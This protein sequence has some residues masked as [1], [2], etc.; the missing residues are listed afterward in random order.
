MRFL[1]FF[2]VL[3]ISI[4]A[5]LSF[6]QTM[7]VDG[8]VFDTSGVAPLSNALIMATRIDDSVLLGFTRSDAQGNF[9]LTGFE[10]DTFMLTVDHPRYD[11]KI[12]FMFGSDKNY[13]ISIP[14][15]VMPSKA[16]ELGEIVIYA[17]KD[18]IYYRGDT[19]VFT[20][21]SFKVD[22]NAVVEDLLK[23]LPGIE[24]DDNG[25]IKSQ[26]QDISKVLVDGDEFFG[27]DPTIATK[28]LGAKAVESVE[29]YE[30]DNDNNAEGE[31]DKIQVLDL[32][33][34]DDYKAGYFGK[35]GGASDFALTPINGEIGTNPFYEGEL[36]FNKFNG[37]Q[38]LS[39]FA[40]TTNTP[41]SSF[42]WGDAMKFGLDNENTSGSRWSPNSSSN[43]SGIPRTFRTGVYFSDKIGKQKKAKL[44][45]NYSF[46]KTELNAITSSE[47]QFFLRDTTYFTEDKTSDNNSQ[48]SHR[49]NVSIELPI[50]SLTT[51]EVRTSGQFDKAVSST[52]DVTEFIDREG[53]N[54]LRTD[55]FNSNQSEGYELDNRVRLDKKF[56][57]KKRRLELEYNF[58]I[59]DAQTDGNLYSTNSFL[60]PL[61]GLS[62]TTD[63]EK[64]N[65]NGRQNH[66]ST[67]TYTE[68][69]GKRMKLELEY[70]LEYGLS[71]QDKSTFDF[72]GD[73]YSVFNDS[74]SNIFDNTRVQNRIGLR[75]IYESKKQYFHVGARV[76]K[77]EI[78]NF[79]KVTG[80]GINQDIIN[81][82]PRVMYRYKPSMSKRFV[83]KYET[84]SQQP[85]INNLMPVPDN[86]NPN[87]I[88]IGNPN[89]VPNY[90]HS[91]N[92]RMS[93]WQAMSGK[94]VWISSNLNWINNGFADSTSYDEIGRSYSKT[95]NV[96][97]NMYT[98]LNG[99]AGFPIYKRIIEIR[100][101]INA[102]YN[103]YY[104]YVNQAKNET[105]NL[106]AGGGL[107]LEF[108]WD[109]LEIQLG[110]NWSY[111]NPVSSVNIASNTPFTTQRYRAEFD[112]TL[113]HGFKIGTDITY[114]INNQPGDGFYDLQYLVW[115]AELSKSFLKTQN[116]QLS[117]MGNDLLNQNIQAARQVSANSITDYKTT[118]ISRYLLLKLTLRFNNNKTK[119]DDFKGWH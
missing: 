119:E 80:L 53:V 58:V 30:T 34:K 100:P 93:S 11:D 27:S 111:N 90:M 40:L 24:I 66:Y 92:V 38:K 73:S 51:L 50:D 2:A 35:I 64:L 89:L 81:V 118:I 69:I 14:S 7:K 8:T 96:D 52:S 106:I 33:L 60:S 62:D 61:I 36:L 116:L 79:N 54:Y 104:N 13:E 16:E 83:A 47:S 48:E 65:S 95:V 42:G 78:D 9:V 56:S 46:N 112:L 41:K 113:K 97:G 23:K 70:F 3:T 115:N 28:N 45:F 105:K 10:V 88:R 76:R 84:R 101:M 98:S 77:I 39:V 12:F 17:Y 68:P 103:K 4:C 5:S 20:A 18:P 6:G 94:H 37:T 26:G 99:G 55:V 74:L 1:K 114:T 87:N 71:K 49:V 67:V 57:K 72:E 107:N 22:Q 19:L 15:I 32:K 91:A 102:Q 117:I 59:T 31:E 110:G 43:S 86:T 85:T 82:L 63:Q 21:D 44:K 109:S 108:E 25:Q 75:W 29:V